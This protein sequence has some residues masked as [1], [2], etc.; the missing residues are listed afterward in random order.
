MAMLF[1]ALLAASWL[2]ASAFMAPAC[3]TATVAQRS[4][5]CALRVNPAVSSPLPFASFASPFAFWFLQVDV[6]RAVASI[7]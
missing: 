4:A 3:T 2:P 5:H 1:A 7:S 6:I